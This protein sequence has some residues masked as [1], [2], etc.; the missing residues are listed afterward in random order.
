MFCHGEVMRKNGFVFQKGNIRRVFVE[1]G[2]SNKGGLA[3]TLCVVLVEELEWRNATGC[4]NVSL[5]TPKA[6]INLL[7][8]R[9]EQS[10]AESNAV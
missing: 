1:E 2:E 10:Q 8:Q 4:T 9:E 5:E 6:G 3:E 7:M